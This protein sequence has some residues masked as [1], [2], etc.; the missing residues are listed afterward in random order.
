MSNLPSHRCH[1][2]CRVSARLEETWPSRLLLEAQRGGMGWDGRM[3]W[4][5][6]GFGEG[7]EPTEDSFR[8]WG[9]R[10]THGRTHGLFFFPPLV[11]K[12]PQQELGAAARNPVSQPGIHLDFGAGR[13]TP[14]RKK[15]S[16]RLLLLCTDACTAA[17]SSWLP[18]SSF[19]AQITPILP[20]DPRA[21]VWRG[22]IGPYPVPQG[23]SPSLPYLSPPPFFWQR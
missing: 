12:L 5:E 10:R 2:G 11:S 9:N 4:L 3:S 23:L 7:L 20:W 6:G 19:R 1:E 13:Q 8:T 18:L 22:R 14:F 16:W 21:D 17:S 15:L